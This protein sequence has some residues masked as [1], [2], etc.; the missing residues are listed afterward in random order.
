MKKMSFGICY[1][2][3]V[4]SIVNLIVFFIFYITSDTAYLDLFDQILLNPKLFIIRFILTLLFFVL[5]IKCIIVW[6]KKDK[7]IIR[8][9]L[10]FFLHGFYILYYY[11]KVIKNNWL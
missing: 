10:L 2:S 6:S 1:I 9:F 8:F 11:P 4:I 7:N 3:T 5:W